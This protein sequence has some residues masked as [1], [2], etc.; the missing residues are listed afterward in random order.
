MVRKE[1]VI[2]KNLTFEEFKRLDRER[3][4]TG[5]DTIDKGANPS[6]EELKQ[7][8]EAMVLRE[9]EIQVNGAKNSLIRSFGWII[10]PLPVFIYFQRHL[11][12]KEV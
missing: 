8:Y 5:T 4:L 12:N 1:I 6:E 11:V 3:P 9:K 2:N 10:I 7:Q